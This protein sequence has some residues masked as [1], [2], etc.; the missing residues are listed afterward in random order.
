MVGAEWRTR[1]GV[2][3]ANRLNAVVMELGSGGT[4][5]IPTGYTF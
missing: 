1:F 3:V 4:Y 2:G 5:T